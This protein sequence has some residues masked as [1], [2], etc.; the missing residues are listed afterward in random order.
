MR[1]LHLIVFSACWR[2]N[3]TGSNLP[4]RTKHIPGEVGA[5]FTFTIIRFDLKGYVVGNP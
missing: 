5:Y 4:E 3:S 1:G 2:H